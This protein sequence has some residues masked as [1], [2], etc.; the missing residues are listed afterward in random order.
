MYSREQMLQAHEKKGCGELTPSKCTEAPARQLNG[1]R[2]CLM[3]IA[4]HRT[5]DAQL[6]IDVI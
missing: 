3:G 1:T 5:P 6:V 4:I 2:D